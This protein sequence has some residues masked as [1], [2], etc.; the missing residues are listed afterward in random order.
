MPIWRPVRILSLLTTLAFVAPATAAPNSSKPRETPE[1]LQTRAAAAEK[2]N[3]WEKAL[4]LYLQA[5]LAGRQTP[6]VREKITTCNRHAAQVRRH[7]DPVFQQQILA[8]P[9]A[10]ALNLYAEVLEKLGGGHVDRDRTAPGKL[11]LSG[12]EE[13]DRALANATF[14]R[15][16]LP[17]ASE[18]TVTKFR[19]TLQEFWKARPPKTV[20][21]ARAAVV[22]LTRVAQT[23]LGLKT[24]SALVLELICGSC[25]SLDEYTVYLSPAQ[26]QSDLAGIAE[27]ATYGLVVSI[28][29]NQLVVDRVVPESWAAQN[30]TVRAGDR[31][32]RLNGRSLQTA[33]G[34][35]LTEALRQPIDG[36]HE[37][38][39]VCGDM[40]MPATVRLP[41]PLPTVQLVSMLNMKDGVGYIKLASFNEN[42]L[43]ELDAAILRL[44][45]QG[46][47]SLVLDLRGNPGGHF[48]AGVRVAERFLPSGIIATTESP[49]PEFAN[50]VFSSES[51]MMAVDVPLTVLI[52]TRTMSAAEVVA[53][54]LKDQG[55]ATIV[56]MPSFGKG[57]VQFPFK[58]RAADGPDGPRSGTLVIT[59]AKVLSASGAPIHK[60]GVIPDILEADAGRQLT[61]ALERAA[62]AVAGMR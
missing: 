27:L 20:R 51:G 40:M 56:G 35:M 55:R 11:F 4:E 24:S 59:I 22:E 50:R 30:T 25:N 2:V 23:D 3:D 61:L 10:E 33:N 54:A 48:L 28:K 34:V 9:T 36:L 31:V 60:Q 1:A 8:L 16:Y 57:V 19:K 41:T 5:Y 49:L 21:E 53:T 14:R 43:L 17:D 44:K 37:L 13:F 18:A 32:L 12:I 26:L 38:E 7:R 62:A 29:Q 6:E 42:T 15:E 58:L 39:L 47:R 52:D 45:D 46:L